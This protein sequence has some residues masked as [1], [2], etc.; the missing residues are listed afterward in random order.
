MGGE[1]K[2]DET[3]RSVYAAS[4]CGV[5]Y[6]LNT[7]GLSDISHLLLIPNRLLLTILTVCMYVLDRKRYEIEGDAG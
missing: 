7:G 6:G 4:V 3:P 1:V 2:V 5:A